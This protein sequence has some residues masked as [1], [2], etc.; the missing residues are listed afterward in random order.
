MTLETCVCSPEGLEL[1]YAQRR[2]RVDGI[3]L[4]KPLS[5][6][7]FKLLEFLATR[8]GKVCLREETSRAVY[9]EKYIRHRDD[10]RL[11]ALIERTRLYIG[12]DQRHPRFIETVRGIGH[13][14]NNY[15]DA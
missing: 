15:S 12:D 14:L 10:A 1:D 3:L 9:E 8:A 4:P 11:D 13:R 7:Q 2:V 5:S 6:R